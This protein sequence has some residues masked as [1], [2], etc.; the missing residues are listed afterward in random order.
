MPSCPVAHKRHGLA[1]LAAACIEAG[2][3]FVALRGRGPRSGNE[4]IQESAELFR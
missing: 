3:V 4:M 1:V 2:A